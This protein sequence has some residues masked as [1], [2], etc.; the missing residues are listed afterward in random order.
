MATF[1]S[2]ARRRRRK[3]NDQ[4]RAQEVN[5]REQRDRHAKIDTGFGFQ[6]PRENQHRRR[7]Q[8]A[9]VEAE[10]RPRGAK[11]SGEKFREI[12]RVP[13]VHAEREKPEDRE[14]HEKLVVRLRD[15]ASDGRDNYRGDVK[16][17]KRAAPAEANAQWAHGEQPES[18]AGGF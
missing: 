16:Q 9:A 2:R 14:Q 5:E 15:E 11:S 1:V 13:G 12:D 17:K 6:P 7:K 18:T 4:Q 3:K 8:P 10:P